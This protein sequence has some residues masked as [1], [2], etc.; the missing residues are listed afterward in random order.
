MD[1]LKAERAR[2]MARVAKIDAALSAHAKFLAAM[3]SLGP[4]KEKDVSAGPIA[5]M[6][7][8]DAALRKVLSEAPRPLRRREI[9]Q[10]LLEEGIVVGGA[11][12][13]N[14]LSARLSRAPE[15]L[16]IDG[17]GYWLESRGLPE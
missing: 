2:L 4:A 17:K 12:P 1:G 13:L 7:A 3:G 16:N 6:S 5:A 10:N 8:F 11:D 14:T 15:V 9:F